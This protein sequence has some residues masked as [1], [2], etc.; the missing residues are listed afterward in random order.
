M[1]IAYIKSNIKW[2]GRLGDDP[3]NA[4]L[5]AGRLGRLGAGSYGQGGPR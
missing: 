1:T 4:V 5:G 2:L 3:L